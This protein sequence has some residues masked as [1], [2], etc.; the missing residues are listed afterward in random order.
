MQAIVLKTNLDF[1]IIELDEENILQQLQEIVGGHI[2]VPYLGDV[3]GGFNMVTVINEEG[4]LRNDLQPS[5][6]IED[7]RGNIIDLVYGPVVL[8]SEDNEGNFKG[9]DKAQTTLFLN[10]L[11]VASNYGAVNKET[12]EK[13]VFFGFPFTLD[14]NPLIDEL[15]NHN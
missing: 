11:L 6:A 5:M 1:D 3:F 8:L 10:S 14:I 7:E 13:C 2:E 12:N 9:L 15:L 4:K